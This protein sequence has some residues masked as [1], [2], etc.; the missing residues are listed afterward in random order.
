MDELEKALRAHEAGLDIARSG[1]E[2]VAESRSVRATAPEARSAAAIID[3]RMR[4]RIASRS[5][6]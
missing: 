6:K 5:E 2:L 3:A 4:E 1:P